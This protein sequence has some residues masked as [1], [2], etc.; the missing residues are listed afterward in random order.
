M[1]DRHEY[2]ICLVKDLLSLVENDVPK[3]GAIIKALFGLLDDALSVA[4]IL[5]A[6][7]LVDRFMALASLLFFGLNQVIVVC[8]KRSIALHVKVF[9]YLAVFPRLSSS[10]LI[11]TGDFPISSY[12]C[13]L[14]RG[15]DIRSLI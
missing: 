6:I 7:L 10:L 12:A 5:I 8:I 4:S 13:V 3:L 2:R 14:D 11:V 15:Y 9:H 1:F